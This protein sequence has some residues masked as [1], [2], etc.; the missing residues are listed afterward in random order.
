M[1]KT[2][3]EL[4]KIVNKDYK[5]AREKLVAK[6]LSEDEYG[7]KINKNYEELTSRELRTISLN[8][9]LRL[10]LFNY[11]YPEFFEHVVIAVLEHPN[12]LRSDKQHLE[13]FCKMFELDWQ[14]EKATKKNNDFFLFEKPVCLQGDNLKIYEEIDRDKL[15]KTLKMASADYLKEVK[16][17]I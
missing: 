4:H 12:L 7:N 10:P 1:R 15:S 14:G 5:V 11:S 17:G 2:D 3:K 9:A 6:L 16:Q 8:L 13:A